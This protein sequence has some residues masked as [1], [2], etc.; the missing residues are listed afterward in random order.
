MSCTQFHC[1][2]MFILRHAWLNLWDKHMTTGRINQVTTIKWMLTMST[3]CTGWVMMLVRAPHHTQHRLTHAKHSLTSTS[4]KTRQCK[5][6]TELKERP[7]RCWTCVNTINISDTNA[8]MISVT[9]DAIRGR[10]NFDDR[11]PLLI[12]LAFL[13][14]SSTRHHQDNK[15][16]KKAHIGYPSRAWWRW[17]EGASKWNSLYDVRSVRRDSTLHSKL[18]V[19]R[20]DC[21]DICIRIANII[22]TTPI[23][24]SSQH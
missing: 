1:I 23:H 2:K 9:I 19:L 13:N 12:P 18:T 8:K 3:K 21:E 14:C 5:F 7:P 15:T 11:L 24:P 4:P 16:F 6:M 22:Q 20:I 17:I 10:V